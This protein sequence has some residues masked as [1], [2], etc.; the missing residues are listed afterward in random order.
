MLNFFRLGFS[1]LVQRV[2]GQPLDKSEQVSDWAQ[3]P[4]SQSQL[5]Y[6]ALDAYAALQVTLDLALEM[7]YL[8]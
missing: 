7:I 1:N 8:T 5:Y 2:L 3:R 4:L 6:A